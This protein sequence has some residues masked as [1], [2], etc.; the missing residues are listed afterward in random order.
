MGH[1]RKRGLP[2]RKKRLIRASVGGIILVGV[3]LFI[4]IFYTTN[5]QVEGNERYTEDEIKRMVMKEPFSWN[6]FLMSRFK[7]HIAYN[8][9][10]FIDS[11]DVE[12]QNH[13]S[14]IIHVNERYPIGYVEYEGKNCY[15]DKNGVVLQ[16]MLKE[17]VEQETSDNYREYADVPLITGLVSDKAEE[18][19]KLKV[20]D[21]RIFDSILELMRMFDKY[22]VRPD[23]VEL[24]EH[25]EFTLHY[26]NVRI[27]L[28]KD[29]K[30]EDKMTRAAAILPKILNESGT[31]HLEDYTNDTHNIIFDK[32]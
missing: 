10:T 13:N 21:S 16:T 24:S 17:E 5:V 26:G 20:K 1:K 11:V 14:I 18:G 8:N 2:K 23:S 6:T 7:R 25:D 9:Q 3:L 12:Y 15:F 27:A 31:L 4:S 29:E 32:D 30:L 28:G 22:G 19:A